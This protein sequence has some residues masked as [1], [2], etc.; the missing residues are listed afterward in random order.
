[1]LVKDN[2]RYYEVI[3][4]SSLSDTHKEIS[5]IGHDIWQSVTAEQVDVVKQYLDKTLKRYRR[6]QQGSTIDINH[7]ISAYNNKL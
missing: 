1:M 3:L 6:V 5:P 4:V 2:R 7:I